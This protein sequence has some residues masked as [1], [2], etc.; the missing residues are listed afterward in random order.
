LAE[1]SRVLMNKVLHAPSV[2]LRQQLPNGGR[3]FTPTA[4]VQ[5]V[6]LPPPPS[7]IAIGFAHQL[8]W[9]M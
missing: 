8:D 2:A 9:A 5:S 6:T 3:T 7:P 4:T 1:W